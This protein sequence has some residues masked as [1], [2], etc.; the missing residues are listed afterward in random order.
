MAERPA[1]SE[2]KTQGPEV[3]LTRD[4][5]DAL[6]HFVPKRHLSVKLRDGAAYVEAELLDPEGNV[7]ASRLLFPLGAKRASWQAHR[8]WLRKRDEAEQQ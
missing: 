3:T 8:R 6:V 2:D 7:T 4:Q 1:S 5:F